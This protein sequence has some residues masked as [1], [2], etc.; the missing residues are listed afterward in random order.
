MAQ[1]FVI[2]DRSQI[3]RLGQ[4]VID[5]MKSLLVENPAFGRMLDADI[6]VDHW[7]KGVDTIFRGA[8]HVIIIHG[9]N[10]YKDLPTIRTQLHIRLAYFDLI[11]NSSGLG[12]VWGGYFMAAYDSWPSTHEAI[13]LPEG[14]CA[15][16]CM[17]VG[18]PKNRFRRIPSRNEPQITWG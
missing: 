12:T 1:W 7:E 18:Y 10:A 4:T 13:G 6:I 16:D 14:N 15:F 3:R 9:S 8:P 17:A 11:A 2:S 5:W